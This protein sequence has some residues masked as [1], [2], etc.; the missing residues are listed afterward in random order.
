M[1]DVTSSGGAGEESPVEEESA[2]PADDGGRYKRRVA[3]VLALLAVLGAWIGILHSDAGT[4]ESYYA[5][6]TTRTAEQAL[7]ARVDRSV[8]RGLNLD[9]DAEEAALV[10]LDPA[11]VDEPGLGGLGST[12]DEATGDEATGDES[13]DAAGAAADLDLVDR[14]ALARRLTFEAERL[15]LRRT[16]LAET[17]VTYN[18]RSSQYQ[19]VLTTLGVALF[20]VGFTLVLDRRTRPPILV[21][22]LLLVAYVAGWAL[23]IHHREVP[24][25]SEAAI[26]AAARGATAMAFDDPEG[27]VA[28][29]DEAV[30]LDDDFVA[31]STGRALAGFESVNPDFPRTLAVVDTDSDAARA[32]GADAE[33]A[34]AL[35]DE[36]DFRSLVVSGTYRFF[37]GDFLGS[38]ERLDEAEAAH[39]GVPEVAVLR[40]AAQL[41]LGDEEGANRSVDQAVAA[42]DPTEASAE[43]RAVA[44]DLFTLLEY[45]ELMVPER[46]EAVDQLRG[47]LAAGEARLVLGDDAAGGVP[48]GATVSLDDVSLDGDELSLSLS[49]ADLPPDTAVSLYLY[50]QP[51]E[52]AAFVQAPE[53]ARFAR[54]EGDGT[55][56]GSTTL[57]RACAPVAFRVDVY[58][59]GG[60]ADSFERPGGPA[61]C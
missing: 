58:L 22:G 4:R 19:T 57:E 9:V 39:D 42:L 35:G 1:N 2:P 27:A 11:G 36:R 23:W 46:S 10:L 47:R 37:A 48:D 25:T 21:P 33:R 29:Y 14:E 44:A 34:V 28:H 60:L 15:A 13:S 43:N 5:R 24:R 51:A 17:R 8:V 12:G 31:A 50:E 55:V 3:V 52:G 16:A 59:D 30:S 18:N 26:E 61:S 41:A 40:A 56:A 53:M 6:E 54:L 49:Y 45:V 7:R 38:V 32:A 20:L